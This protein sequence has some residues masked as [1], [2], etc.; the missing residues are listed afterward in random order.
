MSYGHRIELMRDKTLRL[1]S[2]CGKMHEERNSKF[3]P[4]LRSAK[5]IAKE[6]AAELNMLEA[7]KRWPAKSFMDIDTIRKEFSIIVGD[8]AKTCEAF[9]HIEDIPFRQRFE[10]SIRKILQL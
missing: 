2:I 6:M 1:T 8:L 7:L 10:E 4:L 5:K 3:R 9:D